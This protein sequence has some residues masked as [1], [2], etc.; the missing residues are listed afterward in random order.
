MMGKRESH[1][2]IILLAV[3]TTLAGSVAMPSFARKKKAKTAEKAMTVAGTL[4]YNESRRYAY[5]FLEAVR[6]HE[7]EHYAAAFD[8]LQHCLDINPN[9]AEAYFLR[10]NYYAVLNKDSLALADMEK[11]ARLRPA[12]DIYLE[13]IGQMYIS[14]AKLDKATQA[15]ERL[16]DAHRDRDDVLALLIQIYDRQKDYGKVLSTINRLEQVDGESEQLSMM[17]MN[18]YEKLGDE[19]GAYNTLKGIA[20]SHPNDASYRLMLGNWLMQH[21][22]QAE[23]FD[24]YHAILDAEPDNA[25]AE[26]AMYDYYNATSQDSLAGRM[27]DRIL[28]GKNTPQQTRMQFLRQ[29]VLKNERDGVDSLVTIGLFD[30]VRQVVPKDTLLAQMRVEYY[31][32]KKLPADT[33][34]NALAGLLALQPDNAAARVQLIQNHWNEQDWKEIARLSQPGMLYNPGE[35]AFYFFN[36]LANYYLKDDDA[37]LNALRKGTAE[38]ND[39]ANPE[40]VADLYSIMGEIYHNKGNNQ[41][42]YAAYDSCLQWKPDNI[43]TLNNYAYF[44]S[45][46]NIRLDKAEEMSAKAVKAEPKNST[47]LDTYAW[48]LYRQKRFSEARI[49]IDMALK[50]DTDTTDRK[51]LLEHAGDIYAE[52]GNYG[53]ALDFYEQAIANGG[54]KKALT[55][56]INLYR[57]RK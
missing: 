22:G 49:Y 6:Q 25:M 10:S 51:T 43:V 44:L 41:A 8:L 54:D 35:M 53:D 2:F 48:I 42:A 31:M 3:L 19:K 40:L 24:I 37:A 5:F 46:D 14:M 21:N 45:V 26:S 57:K 55:R 28:Q 36:G 34:N 32:M 9:A 38:I 29:A 39:N 17:R 56:K 23:A 27:M 1:I 18:A 52:L 47:Y 16:Y 11:A 50:N 30:K 20:D 7:A 12:N 33:I 13:R 4:S 15:Y